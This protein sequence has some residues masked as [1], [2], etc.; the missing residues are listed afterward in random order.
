MDFLFAC[1]D[2]FA[3]FYTIVPT[4]STDYKQTRKLCYRKRWPRDMP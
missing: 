3:Q 1:S 4:W 2:I